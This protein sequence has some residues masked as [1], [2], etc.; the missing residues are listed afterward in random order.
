[1]L[2]AELVAVVDG[3]ADGAV[4]IDADHR[5]LHF[6]DAYARLVGRSRLQ[7]KRRVADGARCSD[8]LPLS[9]C[10]NACV[11][12]RA[13]DSRLPIRVDR[14]SLREKLPIHGSMAEL[15]PEVQELQVSA[16][17]LAGGLLLE[18]YRDTTA[19]SRLHARWR[20]AIRKERE[21]NAEL[22]RVV[23]AR[24]SE[25]VRANEELR[26]TQSHLVQQEKMSSLGLLV[27]GVAHEINNPINF[28]VC[29][30]PFL[31]QYVHALEQLLESLES[32]VSPAAHDAIDELRR[33]LDIEYLSH[34]APSLMQSIRNGAQRAAAIV[35]DLRTFS[36][37]GD[38]HDGAID[39]IAGLETTL[40]L[41]RPLL[42]PK[43]EIVRELGPLPPLVG[44]AGQLNQVFMNLV[45]NAIQAVVAR[46][47]GM[48]GAV[49]LRSRVEP[50][51]VRIEVIDEGVG[52]L[53][54]HRDHIF[55]PFFTTKPVG[56]GTGL[57]L[58]ISYG[59]VERHGGEMT[60][61]SEPGRGTTF[62]VRLPL[63]ASPRETEDETMHDFP[64]FPESEL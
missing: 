22:E 54:E 52:I 15:V 18:T 57:G 27:A 46:P 50:G 11:G 23:D 1:M 63:P 13:V 8:L 48:G 24:T 29:N 35:G 30:L 3:C 62:V 45:S 61:S 14:V 58:S 36:H 12:C 26:R 40:N 17:P 60:F 31:E 56:E 53:P 39:L 6:N 37:G 2:S 41:V 44:Q 64:R 51:F 20:E 43:V 34:D 16:T 28:I 32:A 9:L 10:E 49:T 21:Q 7:L 59:I 4:V 38:E 42:G 5:V 33:A 19:E 25:L 55:D 47:D